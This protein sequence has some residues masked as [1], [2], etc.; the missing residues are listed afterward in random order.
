MI[1]ITQANA[2]TLSCRQ[3]RGEHFEGIGGPQDKL[4]Q[5][6]DER[7]G[8]NDNDVVPA[9]VPQ[10][11]GPGSVNDMATQGKVAAEAN[12]G[13]NP[14][15]PGGSKY[16]GSDYYQ[17]ENVPDSISAEGWIAPES[18]IEASRETEGYS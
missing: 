12:V 14:P 8:Y 10:T 11:E 18:V 7:G 6:Y 4:R 9:R 5:A 2:L 15:G 16:R 3:T 1:I 17:P 13:K